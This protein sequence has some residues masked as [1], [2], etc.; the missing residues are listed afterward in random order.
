MKIYIVRHEKRYESPTF[1]TSL[2]NEGKNDAEKL[3]EQLNEI[4]FDYIYSSPFLRTIQTVYPYC[5]KHNKKIN[6]EYSLY[7]CTNDP[8][9][10]NDNYH[11]EISSLK[12]FISDVDQY[13]NVNYNSLLDKIQFP[14]TLKNYSNR[15]LTFTDTIIQ[16]YK[17]TNKKILFVTHMSPVIDLLKIY[18]RRIYSYYPEGK[19]SLL[20]DRT[21]D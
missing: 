5:K 17:N 13:I 10:N 21:I 20:Y 1:F 19:V 7:E 9:F 8:R 4:E 18:K 11:Q 6:V 2:T 3:A 15:L 14:E 12:E 16:K